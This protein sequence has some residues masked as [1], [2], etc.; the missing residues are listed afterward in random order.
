MIH[1]YG[2]YQR[3]VTKGYLTPSCKTAC[4]KKTVQRH[5]PTTG[6]LLNTDL[7][8]KCR[9]VLGLENKH[10]IMKHHCSQT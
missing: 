4:W 8:V 1:L 5:A 7:H 3:S 10:N 6:N 2:H 9:F